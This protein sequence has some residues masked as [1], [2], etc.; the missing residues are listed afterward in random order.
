M[1]PYSFKKAINVW[2]SYQVEEL[3]KYVDRDQLKKI[4]VDR[5]D[6]FRRAV[7][8]SLKVGAECL[9]LHPEDEIEILRRENR[10]LKA[11]LR[12]AK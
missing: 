3:Q 1:V 10:R 9:E 5:K 4:W 7:G 6:E 8:H 12:G 2:Y 11:I